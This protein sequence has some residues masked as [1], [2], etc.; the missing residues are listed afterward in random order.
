MN[1]TWILV[2]HR[3]GA[4]ILENTGSGQNLN[5]LRDIPHPQGGLKSKDIGSDRPA[6][7]VHRHGGRT[8]FQQEQEPPAHLAEVFAR[9][10]AGL[11]DDGRLKRR[12]GRLVLVAE[13]RFLGMLRAALSRATDELVIAT[14]NKNL[15]YLETRE[16]QKYLE[17]MARS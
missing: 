8:T 17:G 5:L 4:R 3:G 11:L 16:L 6:R 10:L 2:A 7:G 13:P 1:N 15:G 9:Q 14:V 12:Y